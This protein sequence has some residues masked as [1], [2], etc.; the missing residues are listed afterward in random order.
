VS[1]SFVLLA[2]TALLIQSLHAIR[3]TSSGFS[4][5]TLTTSIDLFSAGYDRPRAQSFQNEWMDRVQTMPGVESAAYGRIRPFS[6]RGFSSAVIAV[7]GYQPARDE[8]PTVEYNEVGPGY[9]ATTGIPLVSGREFTRADDDKAALV[10]VVNETMAEQYWRGQDPVGQRLQVKDRWMRVVGVA[11]A[12]KYMSILET[13][14]PFFYVPLLQNPAPQVSV[15]LRTSQLSVES[16]TPL[17]ARE[18][19]ALDPNLAASEVITMQ[20]QVDRKASSQQIAVALLGIFGSLAVFL[21][22]IGLYGLMSYAVSQSTRELG[23]RMALGANAGNL[24][25]L[26]ISQGLL[27]TAGGVILGVAVALG[28]TR[29][30]G[31]LLYQVSPRDPLAFGSACLVMLIAALAACFFPA[32][33]ATRTDPVRALRE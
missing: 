29:L 22:A 16:I 20:E 12:A 8:L 5:S 19:H 1:L 10:A 21:A 6:Y 13:P 17:L 24:L 32:W 26:V 4:T 14:Q 9:L 15:F 18:I 23:L 2:G 33:R 31:Y 25:R 28:T 27:L 11:K 7:D 3:N 30:L